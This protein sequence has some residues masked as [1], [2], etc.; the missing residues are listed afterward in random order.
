[1]AG[2]VCAV[3]FRVQ[4]DLRAPEQM[5]GGGLSIHHH[6]VQQGGTTQ[7]AAVWGGVGGQGRPRRAGGRAR[8]CT[9]WVAGGGCGAGPSTEHRSRWNASRQTG[10][11]CP[12]GSGPPRLPACLPACL[13]SAAPSPSPPPGRSSPP[14]PSRNTLVAL[15]DSWLARMASATLQRGV[16]GVGRWL[17]LWVEGGGVRTLA[18]RAQRERH[19]QPPPRQAADVFP[20]GRAAAGV[21]AHLSR[22]KWSPPPVGNTPSLSR[23]ITCVHI[24]SWVR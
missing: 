24:R 22:G 6:H 9:A 11:P 10:R 14:Q 3:E 12:S 4:A 2:R 5:R 17:W 19:R 1:M 8:G 16:G 13:S 18:T 7:G 23:P 20:S 15:P 21:H